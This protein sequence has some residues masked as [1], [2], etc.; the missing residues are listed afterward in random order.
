LSHS[1]VILQTIRVWTKDFERAVPSGNQSTCFIY[2][3]VDWY[4]SVA[5]TVCV[6]SI[7]LYICT[8]L[9]STS[10]TYGSRASLLHYD[11]LRPPCCYF[12]IWEII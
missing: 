6:N 2:L 11:F 1:G 5:P 8:L 7:T 10:K 9:W 12:W 4:V 3:C